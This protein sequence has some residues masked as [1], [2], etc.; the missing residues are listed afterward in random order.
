MD[1]T[2]NSPGSVTPPP[3]YRGLAGATAYALLAILLV[4]A[5]GLIGGAA[6][7]WTTGSAGSARHLMTRMALLAVA[8]GLAAG[9]AR[10]ICGGA[11]DRLL[12]L[13]LV[14]GDLGGILG[15]LAALLLAGYL[16]AVY[17]SL[18]GAPGGPAL[19]N[20]VELAGPTLGGGRFDLAALRG[21]V[22]LIDF[23]ASWC[24]PCRAELPRLEALHAAHRHEGLRLVGVSLDTD[25]AAL[26]KFLKTH[27]LPWPQLFPAEPEERGFDGPLARRFGVASIPHMLVIDRAGKVAARAVHGAQIDEAVARALGRPVPDPALVPLRWPHLALMTSRWWILVGC[28]VGGAAAAALIEAVLRRTFARRPSSPAPSEPA[29]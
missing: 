20:A 24:W 2:A 27:P 6:V 10:L 29:A 19:G 26:E 25:R 13:K 4:G 11:T 8:G 22:V 23:W 12:S 1:P 28:C 17:P 15:F 5:C 18:Q 3:R 21:N 14:P 7:W 9:V 16:T